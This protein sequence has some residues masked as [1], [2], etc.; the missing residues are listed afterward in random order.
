MAERNL[1]QV[2]RGAW[3]CED[4]KGSPTDKEIQSGCQQRIAEAQER[5][6]AAQER[7][8]EQR[9]LMLKDKLQLMAQV[10]E[11]RNDRARDGAEIKRLV[12]ERDGLDGKL[13]LQKAGVKHLCRRIA[14]LKGVVTKLKRR[15]K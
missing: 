15:G 5:M 9:E 10:T 11:M 8:V 4:K 3:D 13:R 2:S 14:A 6:A 1:K 12:V 7:A